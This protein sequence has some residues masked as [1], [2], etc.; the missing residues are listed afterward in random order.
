MS[1]LCC[2]GMLTHSCMCFL[3]CFWPFFCGF[4]RPGGIIEWM[5][6]TN[7]CTSCLKA[8]RTLDAVRR[9]VA[10]NAFS[11]RRL[12]MREKTTQCVGKTKSAL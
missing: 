8:L 2:L 3:V 10:V 9:A 6:S 4:S 11:Q 7:K 12:S 1:S 5:K